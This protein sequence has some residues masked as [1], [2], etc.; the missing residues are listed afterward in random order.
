[1]TVTIN[2]KPTAVGEGR[3][4]ADLIKDLGLQGQPCAAEVNREVVPRRQHGERTLSEGDV[5]ELV[6]LVGGG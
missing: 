3:T 2:G 4:V 5:V 1:M 6:T